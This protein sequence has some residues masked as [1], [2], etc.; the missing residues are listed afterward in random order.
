LMDGKVY[1]IFRGTGCAA[2]FSFTTD[3]TSQS[4]SEQVS[5]LVHVLQHLPAVLE[6][7]PL[8]RYLLLNHALNRTAHKRLDDLVAHAPVKYP[9]CLYATLV[10]GL[11]CALD[12]LLKPLERLLALD[13]PFISRRDRPVGR[14]DGNKLRQEPKVL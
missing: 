13:C 8:V 3:T 5:I 12:L 11:I 1:V 4:L 2:G 14:C 7:V 10:E 9:I 6:Q